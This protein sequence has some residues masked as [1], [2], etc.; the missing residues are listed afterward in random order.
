MNAF[1]VPEEM[2]QNKVGLLKQDVVDI[3]KSKKRVAFQEENEEN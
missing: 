2:M 1:E 3:Y